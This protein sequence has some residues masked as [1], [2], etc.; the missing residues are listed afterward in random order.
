MH[1][2]V[3]ALML[4]RKLPKML[5]VFA[6]TLVFG[7]LLFWGVG[8]RMAVKQAEHNELVEELEMQGAH[9]DGSRIE[10]TF[11]SGWCP[12]VLTIL[13]LACVMGCTAVCILLP[14]LSKSKTEYTLDRLRIGKRHVFLW[15]CLTNAIL[16]L[17]MWLVLIVLIYAAGRIFQSLP[18]YSQGKQGISTAILLNRVYCGLVPIWFPILWVRNVIYFTCYG[19][20]CACFL[21]CG[22]SSERGWIAIWFGL[23][24]ISVPFF[25]ARPGR[26]QAIV[27][28]VLVL[29]VTAFTFLASLKMLNERNGKEGKDDAE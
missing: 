3:F 22:K 6:C 23:I 11:Y 26:I 14:T 18:D 10:Y 19:I 17:M 7:L 16:F 2:S 28:F 8:K 29:T 12:V 13:C 27:C 15:D 25:Y 9:M 1:R 21:R 24:L 20:L 4:R 5:V